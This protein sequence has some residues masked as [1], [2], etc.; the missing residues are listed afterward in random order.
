MNG[1]LKG[2][3]FGV[4]LSLVMWSLIGMGLIAL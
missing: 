3:I 4:P 1:A 2:L